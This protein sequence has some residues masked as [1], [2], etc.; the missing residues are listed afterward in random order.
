[1]RVKN[2]KA[3]KTS[4]ANMNSYSSRKEMMSKGY[5]MVSLSN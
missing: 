3:V 4:G 1:M 2:A 5:D